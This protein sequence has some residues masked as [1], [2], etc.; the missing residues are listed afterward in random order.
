MVGF[1]LQFA[2]NFIE[3][4]IKHEQIH[5]IATLDDYHTFYIIGWLV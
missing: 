1:F 3:L 5:Y 4:N 2:H